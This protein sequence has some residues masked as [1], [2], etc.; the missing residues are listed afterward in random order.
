M[1]AKIAF[2]GLDPARTALL[3]VHMVKG[4]AGEVD[5]PFNRH[6]RQNLRRAAKSHEK[7]S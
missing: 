3:V 2:N 4:V 1:S 6:R 7:K 5:T